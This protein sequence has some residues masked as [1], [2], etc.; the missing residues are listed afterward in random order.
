MRKAFTLI[1]V[2]VSIL[3]LALITLFVSSSILQTKKNNNLFEK[4]VIKDNKIDIITGTL[5]KDLYEL[6]DVSS[7]GTKQYSVLSLKTK[8]SIYDIA[9]PYVVWL[10]LKDKNTLVRL[11]SARKINLPL[12][13]EDMK[14]VFVDIV[15]RDCK[16]FTINISKDKKNILSFIEMKDSQSIVFEV[17]LLR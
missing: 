2:L 14:Y 4:I 15:D 7:I 9:D 10:V 6:I 5:Y 3:L 12:K 11:E 1:E 16:N 17:N 8:N 13:E